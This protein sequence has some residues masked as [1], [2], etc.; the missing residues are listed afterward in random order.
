MVKKLLGGLLFAESALILIGSVANGSFA[1]DRGSA[2]ATFGYFLGILLPIIVNV[3]AGIFL[4]IFDSVSK[5]TY[6]EGFKARKKQCSGIVLFIVIYA[7]FMFFTGLGIGVSGTDHYFLTF[8]VA[9]LPYFIPVV[10]FAMM[11]G[12]YATPYWACRKKLKF[13]DV[14][15]NEFLSV[16]ETFYT[17]SD[18]NS[19]LAS[20]KIFFFPKI[21][22]AIPFDQIASTKF[23]NIGVEQDVI[24]N[25]TNGKKIEIVAGKKQYD[26]IVSILAAYAQASHF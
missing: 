3:F 21:F 23:K 8:I 1:R 6:I 12:I 2:A 17:Y 11:L 18:D 7:V 24:F 13:D 26:S 22:C 4:M 25:L 14:M 15:L 9:T 10:I 19:L 5:K 16:N 20:N